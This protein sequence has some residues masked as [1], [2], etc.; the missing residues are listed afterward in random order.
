MD[1]GENIGFRYKQ[2]KH[3]DFTDK[4]R[5]KHILQKNREN[6]LRCHRKIEGKAQILQMNREE[7]RIHSQRGNI[8]FTGKQRE[9]IDFTFKQKGKLISQVN[10]G[11]K[12][13]FHR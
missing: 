13:R 7:N 4:Q 9:N 8:D 11:Q 10:T 3:K 1:R 2:E 5:K 6:N 12:H